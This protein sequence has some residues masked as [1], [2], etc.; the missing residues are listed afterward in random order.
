M[1][2]DTVHDIIIIR[3]SCVCPCPCLCLLPNGGSHWNSMPI[4]P[5]KCWIF[6]LSHI[7]FTVRRS[8]SSAHRLSDGRLASLVR[9]C[10]FIECSLFSLFLL[11]SIIIIMIRNK[12]RRVFLMSTISFDDLLITKTAHTCTREWESRGTINHRC[13]SPC[14]TQHFSRCDYVYLFFFYFIYT[15]N[16]NSF[17]LLFY[18]FPC[19]FFYNGR[20]PP[21]MK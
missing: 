7:K 2:C 16:E 17:L 21:P 15:N 3:I 13:C 12:Y 10:V 1:T 20:H 6:I 9:M 18:G 5:G 19:E 4:S 14:G 11:Y 8:G